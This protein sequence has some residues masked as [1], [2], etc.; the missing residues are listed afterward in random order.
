MDPKI[1]YPAD[2]DMLCLAKN[3]C[4]W[5]IGKKQS[6]ARGQNS[7]IPKTPIFAAR[8]ET[9][10]RRKLLKRREQELPR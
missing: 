10:Q 7:P 2:E 8:L 4:R 1:N 5:K 3:M 9:K 6:G